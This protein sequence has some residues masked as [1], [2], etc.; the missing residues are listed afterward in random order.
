MNVSCS[1]HI[2]NGGHVEELKHAIY[3]AFAIRSI[4]IPL[5]VYNE[6]SPVPRTSRFALL[7]GT[8]M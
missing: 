5:Y 4:A 2:T 7:Y 6:F 3:N 1:V 8:D